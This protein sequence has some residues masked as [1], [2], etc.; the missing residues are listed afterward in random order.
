[1]EQKALLGKKNKRKQI[2]PWLGFNFA[3]EQK[4]GA[5]AEEICPGVVFWRKQEK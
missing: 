5:S 2:S 3:T 1:M 4:H